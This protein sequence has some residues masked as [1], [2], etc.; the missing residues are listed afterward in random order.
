MPRPSSSRIIVIILILT[1]FAAVVVN[2]NWGSGFGFSLIAPE[3]AEKDQKVTEVASQPR[4]ATTPLNAITSFDAAAISRHLLGTNP[5]PTN[6]HK[7]AADV[8]GNGNINIIDSTGLAQYVAGLQVSG[9]IGTV[10]A[11]PCHQNFQTT[12]PV[13]KGDVTGQ[14]PVIT[15]GVPGTVAVSLP[16]ISGTPGPVIL[17]ITVGDMTGMN[18]SSYDLQ[19]TFDPAVISPQGEPVDIYGTLSSELGV[20]G[21][22]SNPGH[23]I[24][25]GFQLG[26]A[27]SGS[28]TLLNLK[29]NIVGSPGQSTALTFEN[30][31]DPHGRSH[32][33]F[34]FNEGTPSAAVTNGSVTISAVSPTATAS[35]TPTPTTPLNP[36]TSF[37][38]AA[39]LRHLNDTNPL[40]TIDHLCAADVTDNGVITMTDALMLSSYVASKGHSFPGWLTTGTIVQPPCHSNWQTTIP[41]LKGDVTGQDPVIT[42]GVPGTIP[43]SLPTISSRQGQVLIPITVGDITGMDI[44]SY[45]IQISYDYTVVTPQFQSLTV[46]QAGTLSSAMTIIADG[47]RSPDPGHLFIAASQATPLSGSGTLLN[48]RFDLTGTP[49]SFTFLAFENYTDRDLGIIHQGFLFNEGTPSAQTM[50]GSVLISSFTPTPTNSPTNTATPTPTNTPV[51]NLGNYPNKSTELSG[52]TTVV[53]DTPP[54]SA[55]GMNVTA[56]TNF[57]GKLEGDPVTGVVRITNAKPAGTHL[58]TVR[59]LDINGNS[60]TRTFT[61]SVTA[62]PACTSVSFA[63]P[64][65]VPGNEGIREI[66]VGDFNRDGKQDLVTADS[67]NG[68]VTVRY[69]NGTGGFSFPAF[70]GTGGSP[71]SVA[72]SDI[73]RD[74]KQD[75][76]VANYGAAVILLG[77][78]AG[79]FSDPI[80]VYAGIAPQYA[81]IGDFN[82][83]GVQDL[84]VADSFL[85]TVAILLGNATGGFGPPASFGFGAD[86]RSLVVGDFNHDGNQDLAASNTDSAYGHKGLWV[87]LGS[88]SGGFTAATEYSGGKYLPALADFNGDARQDILTGRFIRFGDGIG[89]F[90]STITAGSNPG[91]GVGVVG[92]FNSDTKLDVAAVGNGA[93]VSVYLGNGLGGF[94]STS[95]FNTGIGLGT[96]AVGDFD[97]NGYQDLA[98][99]ATGQISGVY[100]LMRDCSIAIRGTVGYGNA[101]G[102]PTQRVVSNVRVQA[103]GSPNVSTLTTYPVGDYTLTGFGS[104]S[105]VVAADKTGGANGAITSFDAARIAQHVA[106]TVPLTGNARAAADVSGNNVINSFDAGLIAKYVTSSPPYGNAGLW[107]FY[108]VSTI[109]FPVGSTPTSRT[110]ASVTSSLQGENF[111]GILVGEV[112]GN[113]QNADTRPVD[114]NSAAKGRAK[115][116]NINLPKLHTPSDKEI[117][118]P[119]NVKDVAGRGVISYEFD[120]KYDPSVIK[121]LAEPIDISESASRGLFFAVN[122]EEPGLLRVAFYGPVQIKE[123]GVLLNLRFAAVGPDGAASSLSFEWIMFNEGEPQVSVTDGKVELF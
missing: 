96:L 82:N 68:G 50:N 41:I 111:T 118:V 18:I 109:P 86:P 59:A 76:V 92:D 2:A 54:V 7:C 5:L 70:F 80:N 58:I 88:G 34:L 1:A 56:D 104:G 57:T 74:G 71:A 84:A 17:S 122:A 99:S 4:L 89:G 93:S 120:L 95:T 14:N 61:L 69:G 38:T 119:V 108:T 90:G 98:V 60:A 33:G 27:L 121:P 91:E 67:A 81:A 11:P 85:S 106:G 22:S 37:D 101:I 48:L 100:V 51:S 47:D 26:T 87:L 79:N 66:A 64:T 97:G 94:G 39:I 112:S 63:S 114:R 116:I 24:V 72:V 115:N 10:V 65:L 46:D 8:T 107:N 44:S 15:G 25:S 3:E 9:P 110:Y 36:I 19:I 12:V 103:T 6:N 40:P 117:I 23:L 78:G 52:N 31:T 13:L 49:G 102:A 45:D 105:Y 16:V 43:V 75:L 30:Y 62:A 21:N 113:W 42:G 83:D 28:G 55:A 53:P 77:D 20:T 73:N 32:Q 35:G 29:F 123:D